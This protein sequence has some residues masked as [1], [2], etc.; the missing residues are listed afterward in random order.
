MP[1]RA[2]AL[3]LRRTRARIVLTDDPARPNPNVSL[4]RNALRPFV[5]WTLFVLATTLT[6]LLWP[7]RLI[8]RRQR[9]LWAGTPILNMIHQA[10]AERLL[11]FDAKT[12]VFETYHTCSD[13][14]HNLSSCARLPLVGLLCRYGVFIWACL[15]QDRLHFFCDQGLLPG[16]RRHTFFFA[17]LR[18][19]RLLRIPVFLWTYG[20][21]V[22][23]QAATKALGEPNCCSDCDQVGL[24]CICDE[25]RRQGNVRELQRLSTAV[26]SM[27]DMLEYVPGA[28]ADTFY[29]P[30][31][32]SQKERY[33]CAYPRPEDG[34]E[35]ETEQAEASRRGA[36]SPGEA[37]TLR[38]VHAPNHRRFKGT[39]YLV[40][41]VD[42][43]VSRGLPIELILVERV[44]NAEALE[45]YRSADVVFD[46]CL[47][48]FHGYFAIEAMAMGKPV[49]CFIRKP[50]YLLEPESC[51]IVQVTV[52]TIA[53][54][55][56]ELAHDRQ[57][58]EALGRQGRRYVEEHY[59][60][61]AFSKRL[62][63]AYDRLGVRARAG[64]SAA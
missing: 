2:Q 28:I 43:L 23:S 51:P 34:S 15:S 42:E 44:P 18:I 33:R 9:S 22:R 48:G 58:L 32:L 21:D 56:T 38:V 8:R 3:L 29:W 11:G 41:A 14:D 39:S 60:I 40:A 12:L 64:E 61:E 17:E 62:A 30:I 7:L 27:G 47:I 45:I 6:L 54:R 20:A 10:K 46:Q 53:E 16:L 57:Q 63:R 4:L 36:E 37:R 59:T 19:Y 25:P 24:A 52:A 31:D 5:G 35:P 13:F 50:E 26:F 49:L 55:L 1:L